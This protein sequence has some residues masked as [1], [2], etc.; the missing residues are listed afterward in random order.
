MQVNSSSEAAKL[1]SIMTNLLTLHGCGQGRSTGDAIWG[2]IEGAVASVADSEI[3][4][5]PPQ[6]KHQQGFVGMLQPPQSDTFADITIH[7]ECAVDEIVM[8]DE[9]S[10]D[11][12]DTP[13]NAP[14]APPL[15]GPPPP[16]PPGAPPPPPPPLLPGPRTG[17]PRQRLY[18]KKLHPHELKKSA[19]VWSTKERKGSFVAIKEKEVVSIFTPAPA[20]G[21]P[22][23]TTNPPDQSAKKVK[24]FIEH[25]LA[26]PVEILLHKLKST[27]P[28]EKVVLKTGSMTNAEIKRERN[29]LFIE[30]MAAMVKGE[31]AGDEDDIDLSYEQAKELWK[32][33]KQVA[34]ST[35]PAELKTY[36]G[37]VGDLAMPDQFFREMF[38]IPNYDLHLQFMYHEREFQEKTAVFEEQIQHARGS[39][40][41]IRKSKHLPELLHVVLEVGNIM[42]AGYKDGGAD[43]FG[44]SSLERVCATKSAKE[45]LI[46]FITRKSLEQ[47]RTAPCL[48]F[49]KE[50]KSLKDSRVDLK[51]TLE[52]LKGKEKSKDTE[53][54]EKDSAQEDENKTEQTLKRLTDCAEEMVASAPESFKT[55]AAKLR[56]QILLEVDRLGG[57]HAEERGKALEG[58][59]GKAL[60][61]TTEA[62]DVKG[63]SEKKKTKQSDFS[64]KEIVDDAEQMLRS[65]ADGLRKQVSEFVEE[66][67]QDLD[68]MQEM[69]DEVEAECLEM[70]DFF[71]EDSSTFTVREL[72]LT[73]KKFADDMEKAIEVGNTSIWQIQV[74]VCLKMKCARVCAWGFQL[75]KIANTFT[76][77]FRCFSNLWLPSS[78]IHH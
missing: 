59:D 24:S 53:R 41:T 57:V 20:S 70:V 3:A 62:A 46:H 52:L 7:N 25:E 44:I 77:N 33:S 1:T 60:K 17:V 66:A 15:G 64:L 13:A 65:D 16:P 38:A 50:F 26:Q 63:K 43:G 30:K 54:E 49:L 19:T 74:Y 67:R 71:G 29:R 8:H 21:K 14:C 68:R 12:A 42:N 56:E 72:F 73:L 40:E 51:V 11:A 4:K 47:G 27:S 18:W 35:A 31:S 23:G 78:V 10:A 76:H 55:K 36:T 39:V 22:S 37:N 58:L 28:T 48:G 5:A 61:P 69:A 2:A 9:C 32:L 45:S 6:Q 34:A 75:I